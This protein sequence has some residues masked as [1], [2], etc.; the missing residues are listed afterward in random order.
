MYVPNHTQDYGI[1]YAKVLLRL[2]PNNQLY[3][4]AESKQLLLMW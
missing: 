2:Y 1:I 3:H 4:P